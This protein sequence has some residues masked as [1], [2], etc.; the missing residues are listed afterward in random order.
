MVTHT[1][2]GRLIREAFASAVIM[3]F[4]RQEKS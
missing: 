3:L 4:R 2:R 1:P